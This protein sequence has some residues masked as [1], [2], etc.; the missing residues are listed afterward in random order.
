MI[1]LLLYMK[2]TQDHKQQINMIFGFI[3]EFYKIVMGTFLMIF[4][5]QLCN[6]TVCSIMDNIIRDKLLHIIALA[7]NFVSFFVL[8]N[9]YKVELKRENTCIKYLDIEPS[10]PNNY[11]KD[12]IFNPVYDRIK[13]KIIKLNT[14]YLFATKLAIGFLTTNFILSAVSIGYDYAGS[15]TLTTILSFFLLL[16]IKLNTAFTIARKS[17]KK[18][19]MYSSYLKTSKTFNVIDEDHRIN[20]SEINNEDIVLEEVKEIVEAKVEAETEIIAEKVV[21]AAVAAVAAETVAAET[22]EIVGT[23]EETEEL[24]EAIETN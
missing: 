5:P 4:V 19:R 8:L 9:F 21:E 3:I 13:N 20:L 12:V 17:V 11:L 22:T 15:N 1:I 23:K 14:Q 2:L 7:F 16:C 10:K 24:A 18:T 6:D